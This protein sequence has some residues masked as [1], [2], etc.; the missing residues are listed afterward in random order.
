MFT[1]LFARPDETGYNFTEQV[2]VI[3]QS[4]ATPVTSVHLIAPC[5]VRGDLT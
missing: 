2:E 5:G 4:H 3:W 1:M